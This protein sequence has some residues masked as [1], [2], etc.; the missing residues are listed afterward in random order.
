[1]PG[2]KPDRPVPWNN[3]IRTGLVD[4]TVLDPA[5]DRPS[6]DADRYKM[7]IRLL[8]DNAFNVRTVAHVHIW[9][10]DGKSGDGEETPIRRPGLDYTDTEIYEVLRR[11]QG[12]LEPAFSDATLRMPLYAIFEK[13]N[14]LIRDS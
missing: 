7:W 9:S 1:M 14:R 12:P 4:G 10:A 3:S 8:N 6:P 5:D 13:Y 2:R 11:Y